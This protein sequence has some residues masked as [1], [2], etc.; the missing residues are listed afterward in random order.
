MI[1]A[2]QS[3]NQTTPLLK[4][5]QWGFPCRPVVKNPPSSAGDVDLILGWGTKGPH[6]AGQLSLHTIIWE[7]VQRNKKN[8]H[9]AMKTQCSQNKN[10][11][12]NNLPR[13]PTTLRKA[14]PLAKM[15]YKGLA[16]L[17]LFLTSS[18]S[19]LSLRSGWSLQLLFFLDQFLLFLLVLFTCSV[20]TNSLQP[21]RLQ[22][23]R[24][25]VLPHRPEPAQTHVHQVGDA[26]QPSHPL[27]P[28]SPS[29]FNLSQHQGLFQ[30]I[31]SS[32][33][34]A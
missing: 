15:A 32:H 28:P 10:K 19:F 5:F 1:W 33:Q 20:V 25:P 8:Q 21:Y 24:I 27:S 23:A 29:T 12:K 11:N 30:G 4:T 22:H 6:A 2:H 34:E 7:P 18:C 26:I 13:I 9:T 16:G 31:G 14:A 17:C 3:S